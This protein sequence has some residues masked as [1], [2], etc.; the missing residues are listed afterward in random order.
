MTGTTSQKYICLNCKAAT[1]CLPAKLSK[2]DTQKLDHVISEKRVLQKGEFLFQTGEEF[3]H[4][5]AISEGSLKNYLLMEDGREQIYGFYFTGE[6]VG[7]GAVDTGIY[8]SSAV[9]LERT[10]V[11]VIPFE[12][13]LR[14]ATK[15]PNLQ[16]QIIHLM[17]HRIRI[18]MNIPHN[19]S[20]KERIAAFLLHLSA[21]M[22]TTDFKLPMS[23]AEIAS[24]LGLATE[25]VSRILSTLQ[26]ESVI[27]IQGKQISIDNFNV[28]QKLSCS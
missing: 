28:L 19:S 2:K 9:A 26:E 25:T 23:R 22:T 11:C 17:S 15:E 12:L 1:L 6:L 20:A 14:A 27:S 10:K 7:F 3:K 16:R 18:D 21:R 5:Y 8:H 24:H 13:L 4:F